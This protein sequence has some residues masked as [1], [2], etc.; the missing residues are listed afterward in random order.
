M[1]LEKF[2]LITCR[3]YDVAKVLLMQKNGMS[4]VPRNVICYLIIAT[5]SNIKSENYLTP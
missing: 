1:I 4:R 2:Q 5:P 3:T